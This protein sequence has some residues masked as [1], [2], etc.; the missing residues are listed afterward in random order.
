MTLSSRSLQCKG[1]YKLVDWPV[2]LTILKKQIWHFVLCWNSEIWEWP[3]PYNKDKDQICL[4]GIVNLPSHYHL[5]VYNVS[6]VQTCWSTSLF[7]NF[8]KSNLT[9]CTVPNRWNLRMASNL[10]YRQR[11]NLIV[12]A[13][14]YRCFQCKIIT[15]LW[16]NQSFWW[17][18]QIKF[19]VLY[20]DEPVK[21]E[22]GQYPTLQTKVKFDC[23][24]LSIDDCFSK[25][26]M[27]MS[28]H[29]QYF[30]IGQKQKND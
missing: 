15:N 16:I 14:L 9:L 20:C 18:Q 28:C 10:H 5:D 7:D 13:L 26:K 27:A 22:S 6:E 12:M 2:F 8:S 17:F 29:G 21:P 1:E 25:K 3:V 19:D 24:E 30:S 11:S 23:L 4:F